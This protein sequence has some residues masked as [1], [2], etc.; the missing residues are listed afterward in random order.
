MWSVYVEFNNG[1][2]LRKSGKD[3]YPEEWEL[4]ITPFI[5]VFKNEIF[6]KMKK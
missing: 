1:Q 3:S 6:K 4:F 5:K 2:V